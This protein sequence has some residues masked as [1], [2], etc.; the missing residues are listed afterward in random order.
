MKKKI[1][2][3]L[4][5]GAI[6]TLTTIGTYIQLNP[7]KIPTEYKSEKVITSNKPNVSTETLPE[8]ET[9][10]KKDDWSGEIVP[11][12]SH[13]GQAYPLCGRYDVQPAFRNSDMKEKLYSI[14]SCYQI[15]VNLESNNLILFE[16]LEEKEGKLK[17]K[18]KGL[19]DPEHNESELKKFTIEVNEIPEGQTGVVS[20]MWVGADEDEIKKQHQEV[21]TIAN[22]AAWIDKRAITTA[23][24]LWDGQQEHLLT[25]LGATLEKSP[26]GIWYI[27]DGGLCH[28][29]GSGEE[30]QLTNNSQESGIRMNI[31]FDPSADCGT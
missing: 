17:I 26:P 9:I 22:T 1:I 21:D 11:K 2:I 28:G 25:S 6:I 27:S 18:M 8:S 16:V 23:W 7:N 30:S 12:E 3:G 29:S 13:V 24:S 31:N 4:I 19:A 20:I 14:P 15:R 5:V 10:F